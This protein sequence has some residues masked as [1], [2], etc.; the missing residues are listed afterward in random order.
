[1]SSSFDWSQADHIITL[2]RQASGILLGTQGRTG[3]RVDLPHNGVLTISG[4]LHDHLPNFN[5]IVAAAKLHQENHHLLLQELIHGPILVHGCDMS[6]RM[7]ARVA[8]LL[9]EF[10]G[11]VHPI[12]GNHENS[13]LTRVGVTKGG[14]NSVELFEDGLSLTFGDDWE[15]VYDAIDQFL[16]A[17][18]LA[19]RTPSGVQ[20]THSLPDAVLM[21]RF[22]PTVIDREL[23][24]EDRIGPDGGAYLT[25][26]GRRFTDEQLTT[27]M[28]VWPVKRFIIG[29]IKIDGGVRR[30]NNSVVALASDLDDGM[31]VRIT[32]DE[33][34]TADELMSRATPIQVLPFD[35]DLM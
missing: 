29:H 22:D 11:R 26:W 14:G 3:C 21:G 8:E 35:G 12:L 18:P 7:L 23:T 6:W 17:M 10:P 31:L 30:V 1:M 13:Q 25:T 15:Q 28:E 2:F 4:D 19:V 33:C 16:L 20:C 27:L 34:P 9:L 24:K 5:R 32:L